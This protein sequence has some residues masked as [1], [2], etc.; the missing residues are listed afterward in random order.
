MFPMAILLPGF[1]KNGEISENVLK[2]LWVVHKILKGIQII[3]MD[4]ASDTLNLFIEL[5]FASI[6]F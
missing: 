6:F 1:F 5:A 4:I 3:A 2:M